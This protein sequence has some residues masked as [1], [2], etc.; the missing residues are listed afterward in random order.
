[1]R[2]NA[3]CPIYLTIKFREK[4]GQ[5][6]RYFCQNLMADILCGGI[7]QFLQTEMF[8]YGLDVLYATFSFQGSM[9]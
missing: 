3:F 2:I 4:S 1:M 7:F 8:V 5:K 9:H 6:D